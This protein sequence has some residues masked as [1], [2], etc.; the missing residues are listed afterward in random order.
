MG[1]GLRQAVGDVPGAVSIRMPT[2]ARSAGPIISA[3]IP[4]TW[5][6][7]SASANWASGMRR[8][9]IRIPLASSSI[10]RC[11]SRWDPPTIAHAMWSFARVRM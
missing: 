7:P 5:V 11:H 9:M 1:E 3:S 6:D 8:S 10:V 4:S 2:R